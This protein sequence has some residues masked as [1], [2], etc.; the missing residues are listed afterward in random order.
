MDKFSIV[1][2]AVVFV[3]A[4]TLGFAGGVRW[5]DHSL[6]KHPEKL[7]KLKARAAELQAKLK[8]ARGYFE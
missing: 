5:L 4:G 7:D 1:H 8:K 6:R 2:L 3:V